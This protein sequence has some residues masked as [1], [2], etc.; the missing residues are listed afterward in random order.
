MQIQNSP[1]LY[2]QQ[3][4]QTSQNKL[5]Q[6]NQK[7]ADASKQT[8]S[9]PLSNEPHIYGSKIQDGL[10]EANSSKFEVQSNARVIDTSDKTLGSLID[11]TV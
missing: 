11:I 9:Q 10:I 3:G 5:Y 6:T 7:V 2:G 8:L 1:F 4:L